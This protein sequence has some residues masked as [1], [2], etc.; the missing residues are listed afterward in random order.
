MCNPKSMSVV[1]KLLMQRLNKKTLS[2]HS[3][4]SKTTI[5]SIA[6]SGFT[7]VELVVV[8]AMIGI[9]ASIAIPAFQ[10]SGDK[11]KQKEASMLMNAYTKAAAAYYTENGT[12]ATNA[13]GLSQFVTVLR[14]STNNPVS[15]KSQTKTTATG[16]TWYAPSGLFQIRMQISGTRSLFTATPTGAYATAG[17][18]SSSCYNY[19]TGSTNVIDST[20]KGTSLSPRASSC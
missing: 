10:S 9:L 16:N 18:G 17:Y 11:A 14:C 20:R 2:G 5:K 19:T 8:V 6:T 3:A 1:A 12:P 13:T 4:S 15:C 7:L